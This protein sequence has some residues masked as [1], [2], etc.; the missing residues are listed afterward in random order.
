MTITP[1]DDGDP[2]SNQVVTV[3][4]SA[5]IEGVTDPG[6]VTLTILDNDLV[7]IDGICDRT[8]RVRDRILVLLE[9]RHSFKGGCGDVNETHLA[10]LE[11]LDLGRNPST[12]SAFTMS[13]QSAS[14]SRGW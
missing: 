9:N 3:S 2:E 6:D 5:S 11:S 10:Q 7:S 1:V 14:T 12:E 4:G 13:L 8:W